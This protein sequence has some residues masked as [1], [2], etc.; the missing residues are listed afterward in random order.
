[1]SERRPLAPHVQA[2]VG[3]AQTRVPGT[4]FPQNQPNL[5]PAAAHVRAATEAVQAKRAHPP[6]TSREQAPHVR[7][8]GEAIQAKSAGPI[9]RNVVQP[10]YLVWDPESKEGKI[11]NSRLQE[12]NTIYEGRFGEEPVVENP[13]AQGR[14]SIPHTKGN[15]IK[16]L[17]HGGQHD[18]ASLQ[19]A[20][21]I[22]SRLK[23]QFGE[24]LKTSTVLFIACEAGETLVKRIADSM[25][26]VAPK[27]ST[28]KVIG[29]KNETV[30]IGGG[31]TRVLKEKQLEHQAQEGNRNVQKGKQNLNAR[32]E[33]L[34]PFGEGWV[35]YQSVFNDNAERMDDGAV[36]A[37]IEESNL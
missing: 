3:A 2:T 23:T 15:V 33:R 28:V 4:G 13:R 26:K 14:S 37:I 18:I 21:V 30:I 8:A 27:Y 7:K 32:D 31:S 24:K 1:M 36:R 34:S 17:A 12:S 19:D 29:P 35:G 5:R 9:S 11:G 25:G 10:T 20:G 22:A 16:I 6:V